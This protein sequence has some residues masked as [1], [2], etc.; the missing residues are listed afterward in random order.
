MG[1]S[2]GVGARAAGKLAGRLAAVD[3]TARLAVVGEWIIGYAT[4]EELLARLE[5]M[6]I[7]A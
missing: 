7:T 2:R 3:D 4:G 5:G 1:L 6:G